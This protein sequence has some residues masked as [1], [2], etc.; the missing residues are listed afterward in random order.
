MRRIFWDK[1]GENRSLYISTVAHLSLED[2]LGLSTQ[3]GANTI[4]GDI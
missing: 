2:I 4:L 1:E 3:S